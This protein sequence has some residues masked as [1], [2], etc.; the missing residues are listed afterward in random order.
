MDK[1]FRN[2]NPC[3]QNYGNLAEAAYEL[4]PYST[5]MKVNVAL[6]KKK[7][8]KEL[9]EKKRMITSRQNYGL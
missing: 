5:A 4:D 9:L 6:E 8:E 1:I 3:F 2:P 7:K